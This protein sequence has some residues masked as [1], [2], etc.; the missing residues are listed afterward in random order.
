[1]KFIIA[2]IPT[3]YNMSKDLYQ[4]KKIVAGLRM[5]YE[6]IDASKKSCMLFSKEHMDDIECLHYC[7]SRYAKVINEY[8]HLS[9]QKLWSNSFI[10]YL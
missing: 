1:M 7:R 10:T 6:K 3:K 5:D 8:G 2:L 9:P 4:S